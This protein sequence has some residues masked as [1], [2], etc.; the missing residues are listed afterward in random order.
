M[1]NG[2]YYSEYDNGT[3][4]LPVMH[5]TTWE[6]MVEWE[7][8]YI[9]KLAVWSCN[10]VE[11]KLLH[12]VTDTNGKLATMGFILYVAI[13]PTTPQLLCICAD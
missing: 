13:T 8:K 7:G 10:Q 5:H 4:G 12:V 2:G 6:G 11:P 3:M 1:L 9:E